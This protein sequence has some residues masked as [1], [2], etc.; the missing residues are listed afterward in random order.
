[1]F[2]AWETLG[3]SILNVCLHQIVPLKAQGSMENRRQKYCKS[4]WWWMT[5]RPHQD[6]W[7]THELTETA[8]A[9]TDQQRFQPALR[10]GS[11]QGL[12]PQP[13]SYLHLIPMG[14]GEISLLWW[15]VNG[16]T[17]H[18]SR[19]ASCPGRVG[20]HKIDSMFCCML[21]TYFVLV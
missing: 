7:C 14:K 19:Q 12:P 9:C 1:M 21:F 4:H 3:Y 8:A 16:Y 13:R 5:P 20:Q 11:R 2:R 18:T 17:N 15:C 6:Q 10:W